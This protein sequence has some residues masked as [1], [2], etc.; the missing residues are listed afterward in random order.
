[1]CER[2]RVC[3]CVC[4]YVRVYLWLFGYMIVRLNGWMDVCMC[5]EMRGRQV[6]NYVRV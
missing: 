5:S 4:I 2:E 1:M 6:H 3:V